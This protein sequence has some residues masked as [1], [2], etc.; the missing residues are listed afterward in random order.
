MVDHAI[1][2]HSLAARGQGIGVAA[3]KGAGIAQIRIKIG[4]NPGSAPTNPRDQLEP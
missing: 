2:H 1:E 3:L 4:G